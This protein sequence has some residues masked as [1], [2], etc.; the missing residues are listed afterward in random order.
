MSKVL[1]TFTRT[2]VEG[3]AKSR[4]HDPQRGH[5]SPSQAQKY[6]RRIKDYANGTTIERWLVTN[7]GDPIK[8]LRTA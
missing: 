1:G 2:G 3:T 7:D 8:L 5:F 4:R 6:D